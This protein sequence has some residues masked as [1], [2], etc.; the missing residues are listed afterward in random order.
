ME[1]RCCLQ[2]TALV[3]GDETELTGVYLSPLEGAFHAYCYRIPFCQL[4]PVRLPGRTEGNGS[5]CDYVYEKHITSKL[6]FA[7]RNAIL[8][9]TPSKLHVEHVYM[10]VNFI[11][12]S[13]VLHLIDSH[14]SM[15]YKQCFLRSI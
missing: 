14:C 6:T 9:S 4:T 13:A 8:V 11:V 15:E 7:R 12:L 10:P 2:V 3:H 1:S 5:F